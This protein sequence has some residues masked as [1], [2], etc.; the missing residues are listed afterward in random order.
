MTTKRTYK[1]RGEYQLRLGDDGCLDMG[2]I[3][4]YA[5]E[6]NEVELLTPDGWQDVLLEFDEELG[7][8]ATTEAHSEEKGFCI[9]TLDLSPVGLFARLPQ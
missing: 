1:E 5:N 9:V 7:W 2:G 3:R 6:R 4:F 8:I